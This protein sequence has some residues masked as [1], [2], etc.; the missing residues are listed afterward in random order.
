MNS[1]PITIGSDFDDTWTRDPELWAGFARMAI[2]RGHEVWCITARAPGMMA[3]VHAVVAP[4]L[5]VHKILGTPHEPKAD[6]F[7]TATG[8]HIDIWID[9]LPELVR[10]ILISSGGLLV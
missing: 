1:V 3:E 10:P 8:R 9:D 4:V 2:Q 6:A 7:F 5:G